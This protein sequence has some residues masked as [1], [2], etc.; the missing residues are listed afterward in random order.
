MLREEGVRSSLPP[1]R[2]DCVCS[3]GG[4]GCRALRVRP[5]EPVV[6]R[7]RSLSEVGWGQSHTHVGQPRQPLVPDCKPRVLL[8]CPLCLC[9]RT[10]VPAGPGPGGRALCFERPRQGE[11]TSRLTCSACVHVGILCDQACH[12][13]PFLANATHKDPP[14]PREAWVGGPFSPFQLHSAK[15]LGR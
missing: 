3:G 14:L 8:S 4:P 1:R 6:C 12:T 9:T 2:Q 10:G 11:Q 15:V 7:D 5:Q 13:C